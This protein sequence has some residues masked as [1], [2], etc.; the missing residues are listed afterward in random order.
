M[1]TKG[2][3]TV[4]IDE[5]IP[6]YR[7]DG[8]DPEHELMLLEYAQSDEQLLMSETDNG[9]L[10]PVSREELA[11]AQL[12]D[13]FCSR[14]R[15]RSSS[16]AGS[17]SASCSCSRG[18]GSMIISVPPSSENPDPTRTVVGKFGYGIMAAEA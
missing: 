16:A 3:T 7:M 17:S 8:S 11:R 4:E 13:E 5:E 12:F 1:P 10:L 6:C 14:I 9:V 2:E 15:S 18:M